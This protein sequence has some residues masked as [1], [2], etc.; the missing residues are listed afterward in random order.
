[1]NDYDLKKLFETHKTDRPDEGFSERVVRQ[2]PERKSLL[3]QMV[4]IAAIIIGLTLTFAM[5]GFTTC[6]LEQIYS[7]TVSINQMQVPTASA[8]MTYFGLLTLLGTVG[9]SVAQVDLV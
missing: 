2:L 5:P 9:Y 8:I 7:L 1:M 6:V 3:P 4:M